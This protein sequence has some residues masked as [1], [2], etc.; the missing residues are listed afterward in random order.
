MNEKNVK[1]QSRQGRDFQSFRM[2]SFIFYGF[3]TMR[4][5]EML[6]SHSSHLNEPA[7]G[8]LS[9]TFPVPSLADTGVARVDFSKR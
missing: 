7:K 6:P 2:R 8:F 5:N 1:C 9:K 4:V 3:E